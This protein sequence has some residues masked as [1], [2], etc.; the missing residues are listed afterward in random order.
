MG[1]QSLSPFGD[2]QV[3]RLAEPLLDSGID[4]RFVLH[5]L[6]KKV[7][8]RKAVDT[9]F[10][11]RDELLQPVRFGEVGVSGW[12][13]GRFINHRLIDFDCAV[14]LQVVDRSDA[15]LNTFHLSSGEQG[16]ACDGCGAKQG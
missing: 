13:V 14:V 2:G 7:G 15:L 5:R 9:E 8:S 3:I 6:G 10:L 16:F 11:L 12:V 4:F 1:F